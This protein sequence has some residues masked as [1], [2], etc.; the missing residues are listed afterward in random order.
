MFIN[1]E[2]VKYKNFLSTGNQF[3]EIDLTKKP[4]T[5]IHGSNGSGKTTFVD[6]VFFALF[7]KS[8]RKVK[9]DSV[10]NYITKKHTVVELTFSIR[11]DTY[12]ICRGIKPALFE[13]YRNDKLVDKESTV[14]EYQRYL[15]KFILHMNEKLFTQTVLLGSTNYTPFMLLPTGDRRGVIE[16]LLDIQIFSVMNDLAK[17]N[18]KVLNTRFTNTEYS[19]EKSDISI[20]HI[21]NHINSMKGNL[22]DLVKANELKIDEEK[23]NIK[24]KRSFISTTEDL[25]AKEKIERDNIGSKE[26]IE[27]TVTSLKEY[28]TQ[29]QNLIKKNG[30]K[31]D[32]YHDNTTCPTCSQDISDELRT[33]QVSDYEEQND[34][35]TDGVN[36]A[37]SSI[38]AQDELLRKY[39]LSQDSIDIMIDDITDSRT[40]ITSHENNIT[41]YKDNIQELQSSVDTSKEEVKIKEVKKEKTKFKKELSE[42]SETL[43]N[44]EIVLDLLKDDGIKSR[45]VKTYIP[46][47]NKLVKKYLD[48]LDFPIT[49]RFD[50]GF[51]EFI[52]V[53]GRDEVTY[54]NLSEGEKMRI[55]LALIFSFREL[56]VM[57][58]ATHTNLV[59]FDEIA[60][61]SLDDTGWDSFLKILN[62]T[63]STDKQN[64]FIISHKGESIINKFDR[65]IRFTKKGGRFSEI[66]K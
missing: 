10:V 38:D 31:I 5:L 61:S 53:R 41:T 22:D 16:S 39:K 19:I 40:S 51:N 26:T 47:I 36:R 57:R 34:K 20:D 6:A 14:T 37:I 18:N 63:S 28:K 52:K 44:Y 45:I 60:D 29:F 64:V 59:I 32:F 43:R 23:K 9:K 11:K 46:V 8:F 65:D 55:N 42:T 56:S 33:E 15:E 1:F 12:K 48:I 21:Q 25:I 30:K 3:T 62:A 54:P 7:G 50:E 24:E 49:F 2:K 35:F 58:N 17:D 13:I 4:K 66:V 27:K